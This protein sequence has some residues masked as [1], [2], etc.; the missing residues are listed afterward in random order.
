MLKSFYL[1]DCRMKATRIMKSTLALLLL[2][3]MVVTVSG[4]AGIF[5]N[6]VLGDEWKEVRNVNVGYSKPYVRE[7]ELNNGD[8]YCDEFYIDIRGRG[9]DTGDEEGHYIYKNTVVTLN[10]TID[11]KDFKDLEVIELG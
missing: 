11:G 3:S 2:V 5:G 4:C 1:G 7:S 6:E 10:I 9:T 8:G